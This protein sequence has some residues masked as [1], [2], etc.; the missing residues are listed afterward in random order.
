MV[1]LSTRGKVF[2]GVCFLSVTSLFINNYALLPN[3]TIL[4]APPYQVKIDCSQLDSRSS[5]QGEDNGNDDQSLIMNLVKSDA[6]LAYLRLQM[7]HQ[8]EVV[9]PKLLSAAQSFCDT[10]TNNVGGPLWVGSE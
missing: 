6:E 3:R 7:K 5:K 8:V 1:A 10:H 4:N 9:Q 2:I